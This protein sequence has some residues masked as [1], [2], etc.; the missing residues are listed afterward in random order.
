M[1]TVVVGSGPNGLA[2]AIT[3]AAHGRRV[4][5]IEGADH[6]GGGLHTEGATLPGFLH[7]T[8]SSVYPFAA[9]SPLFRSL[10]LKRHGL[11][12]VRPPFAVAHPLDGGRAAIAGGDVAE[13]A[14]R[15]GRDGPA[16]ARLIEPLVQNAAPI[17]RYLLGPVRLP[18]TP[19]ALARFGVLGLQPA[20]TLLDRRFVTEEAKALIAGCAAHSMLP[21]EEP[22]TA[23]FG[24][25]LAMCAHTN[26][27]PFA[28]GGAS[29]LANVLAAELTE[30]GG[31]Y[32]TGRW[33]E[34][35]E[36]IDR[37]GPLLL[38]VAPWNLPDMAALPATYAA[39]LRR[40][41]HGPGVVKV[42]YALDAA[43]PWSARD[44]ALAGTVHLGGTMEEISASERA[45]RSGYVSDSPFVLATQPSLFDP[46]RAP[47]GKHVFWAYCHVPNGWTEDESHRI[48]AQIERFAPG[49]T[50]R[51]LERRVLLPKDFEAMN[52]GL[53]GGDI[54]SGSQTLLQLLTRPVPRINPYA[55]PLPDVYLCSAATPPG[56]GV[57]GMC[58][59]RA[60][61][62]AL[63]GSIGMR[64]R[65]RLP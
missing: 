37:D 59:Y 38:D 64:L 5:L 2:A 39:A 52:P 13:T 29:S 1:R 14:E 61:L 51:I 54:G 47:A 58:G 10:D 19:L 9:S 41:R 25:L 60:A 22:A 12:W 23:A 11:S 21:M 7:D 63:D 31:T 40:Y 34:H 27:W 32:E 16:Y 48:D 43:V 42:D 28:R 20:R 18:A 15:L 46:A 17:L 45:V 62:A 24:L 55:T 49:F 65:R 6:I 35:V 4:H 36:D 57:H 8:C 44:C 3:L 26:G 30:R 53:R 33:V 56:S 50:D